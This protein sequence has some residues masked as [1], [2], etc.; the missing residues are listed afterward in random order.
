MKSKSA[1]DTLQELFEDLSGILN[2]GQKYASVAEMPELAC[3]EH[4]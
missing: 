3:L 1:T 4:C 2:K